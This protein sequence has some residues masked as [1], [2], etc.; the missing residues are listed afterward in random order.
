MIWHSTPTAEVLEELSVDDKIGLANGIVDERLKEYGKN[1]VTKAENPSF[2]K[3]FADQLKSKIVIVLIVTALVSFVVSLMTKEVNAFS[4]LLIIAIVIINALISAYHIYRCNN[5]LNDIKKFTNPSATVLREGIVKSINADDLVPGDIIL[6][7]EG[8]YVSADARIIESSEFRCNESVLTGVE[9]PVEKDADALLD[10]ISVV[11][12]RSN[13]VFF[14]SNVVHGNAKAVV[15]STGINTEIGKTSAIM[16][17]TGE[18]KLPLQSQL[19]NLAKFV[20]IAI[21][22]ICAFVFLL[23]M[24]Q[25]FSSENFAGMTVR[26]FL[27]AIALAVAAIPEGLP[28]ITTIVVAIGIYRILN[29]KI[30]VKDVSAAELLG[31]TDI[32]CCDKTGVFTRNKMI[33]NCIFDG[34]KLTEIENDELDESAAT[35][36]KLATVC[37]TLENDSTESAIEKAC[38]AY[39]SMSKQD[40][41]NLF[42]HITEIPF[43]TERKTMS[44]ITMI[45]ERPFAIIKGA[46]ENVVPNCVNCNAEEILKLNE[47]LA[48]K[49]LRIICIAMKPLAEIPANPTPDEIETNLIFAGLL[50]LEDPPREG[51]IDEIA[52]CDAAGIKTLMITGDNLN[53]A[54]AVARRIGILKDGTFAI[55][56]KELGEMTD[57]ELS[58]NIEKYSVYARVSPNDKLRIVKAWQSKKKIITITGD[59]IQDADALAIADV[60]CAIGKFGADVAK[61]N[62]DIIISNNRFDSVVSAVKESRGLFSN[63]RKSVC[64]LLSCNFAE[65]LVIILGMILFGVPPVAAVQLLWINLLTDCAPAISLSMERA[66]DRVMNGKPLSSIGRIFNHKSLISVAVQCLFMAVA[67]LIAFQFGF[68]FGDTSD[69][70]T[71]AFTTLGL[72]QIFHCFNNKCEGTVFN[73][74]IFDNSFMNFS[75]IVTLFIIL[76]LIFTPAGLLFGLTILS[77]NQF[78][79]CLLLSIL[80]IPVC[81][82]LKFLL[83]R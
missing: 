69:S 30:Y 41:D 15:V 23:G 49:A 70:T 20:N 28:A 79:I 54:K 40:I 7:Q 9:V 12:E 10:D 77:L 58:E 39:N 37:S 81:E 22:I 83:N 62:A 2:L 78:L 6:L 68:D 5:S 71:M 51:V 4:A 25:N 73:R 11:A 55:T 31:K 42:P 61:G 34:K 50:G 17:Q 3:Y 43:D 26:M 57:E 56:G 27:N 33:L 75:V 8:D 74:K 14:G 13:M 47:N 66:E 80:I 48:E 38:L 35:V 63:I 60:G 36:L 65:I 67:T 64:Y 52:A 53:T 59:S 32:I 21:F 16:E 19:D 24:I 44:V 46:P 82:I 45:N 29:D 76:F 72:I 18:G 1:I